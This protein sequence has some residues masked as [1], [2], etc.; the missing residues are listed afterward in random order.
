MPTGLIVSV[1]AFLS[2]KPAILVTSKRI[3]DTIVSSDVFVPNSIF[4]YRH[5][6][7]H[8]LGQRMNWVKLVGLFFIYYWDRL[9]FE[10]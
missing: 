7:E 10:L 9:E 4:V 1:F 2:N 8:G 3:V 6:V 5:R